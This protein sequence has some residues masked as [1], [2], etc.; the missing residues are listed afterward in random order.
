MSPFKLHSAFHSLHSTSCSDPSMVK[1]NLSSKFQVVAAFTML[2]KTISSCHTH[3]TSRRCDGNQ[4]TTVTHLGE[5]KRLH[6][7][8]S[9][10]NYYIISFWA[11]IKAIFTSP[12][13]KIK[14]VH[15]LLISFYSFKFTF[16]S[17]NN[18]A[19]P[20]DIHSNQ[21]SILY[22]R[23]PTQCWIE[24]THTYNYVHS[25]YLMDIIMSELVFNDITTFF[26][27]L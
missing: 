16:K 9:K 4:Q 18:W 6:L 8:S 15:N 26:N 27:A 19:N 23:Q 1:L 10:Q 3:K 2:K 13:V 24:W 12:H 7:E 11:T 20:L 17:R 14:S 25:N 5:N 22:V 21:Y